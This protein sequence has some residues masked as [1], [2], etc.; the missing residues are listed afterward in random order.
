MTTPVT[1][2]VT[3]VVTTR[4]QHTLPVERELTEAEM[5]EIVRMESEDFHGEV[6]R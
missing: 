4:T 2:P 6:T 5:W 1:N 3:N